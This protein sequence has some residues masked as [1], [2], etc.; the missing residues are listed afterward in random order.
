VNQ[1]QEQPAVSVVIPT[2]NRAQLL[3]GAL[4][5]LFKQETAGSKFEIIVVDNN[6]S[7]ETKS[8]V[9]SLMAKCD[10]SLRYVAEPQ[11]GNAYARNTGIE[12]AR[13]QV[14]AFLDDDVTVGENWIRTLKQVFDDASD[15][16]F[17]G[18]RVLP[19][20]D[21]TLPSWLT[22]DHWAPLALLDY[23]SERFDV[24]GSQPLGL[25]TANIAFRRSVFD[26]S[27]M[28]SPKLQRVK[29]AIGSLEDHEFLLR[30]CRQGKK[31]VYEPRLIALATIDRE[32]LTKTYHRRWHTGHGRF[33]AI[34]NDPEFERS[35]LTIFGMPAHLFKQTGLEFLEWIG[36]LL[37]GKIDEAFLNE[38]QLRF[39]AGYFIQ[40]QKDFWS[41]KR[42]LP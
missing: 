20:G 30:V 28:F 4:L 17:V 14:V 1:I 8:V 38:R 16:G 10:V 2:Y 6:S 42:A 11:Q 25:L 22:V 41:S 12:H 21:E 27:G 35:R 39:F 36:K 24:S 18:G 29:N 32:R 15:I 5:D 7:D 37:R 26:E 3:R 19:V 31:G 13:A 23:G 40:R 34:L 33:Y 9:E